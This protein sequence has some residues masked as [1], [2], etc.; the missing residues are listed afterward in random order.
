MGYIHGYNPVCTHDD[1]LRTRKSLQVL[2]LSPRICRAVRPTP[3][4]HS[5]CK[6]ANAGSLRVFATYG[7]AGGPPL[8][9]AEATTAS[10]WLH[11]VGRLRRRRRIVARK[12]ALL[13]LGLPTNAGGEF[14][15]LD[16]S[17]KK[18]RTL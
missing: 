10:G 17:G 2:T 16:T 3:C 11:G 12:S 4:R 15:S 6:H 13:A 1:L 8:A 14:S 18:L 7:G 5:A 9:V